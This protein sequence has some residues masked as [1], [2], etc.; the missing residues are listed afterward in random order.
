[1]A[2]SLQN[3]ALFSTLLPCVI[4]AQPACPTTSTVIRLEQRLDSEHYFTVELA[5]GGTL[6]LRGLAVVD[7]WE[8]VGDPAIAELMFSFLPLQEDRSL[9]GD[10]HPIQTGKMSADLI[11]D[12]RAALSVDGAFL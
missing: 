1:M 4:S 7:F 10:L 11:E 9:P 8:S 5:S 6:Y 3:V 12:G 2:I